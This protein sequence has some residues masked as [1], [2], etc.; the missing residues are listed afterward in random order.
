MKLKNKIK[1]GSFL[2]GG[3][4]DRGCGTT[5]SVGVL[6]RGTIFCI[7]CADKKKGGNYGNC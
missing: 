6:K 2:C 4:T 1:K 7:K 5:V 3:T